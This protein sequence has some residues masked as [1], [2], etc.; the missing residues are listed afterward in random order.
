MAEQ[1]RPPAPIDLSVY[2][3]D[4]R[5]SISPPSVG[6][7]PVILVVTN[8][9]SQTESLSIT[10]AGSGSAL[11]L[12]G[13]VSPQATAQMQV[14]LDS[15]GEYTVASAATGNTDAGLATASGVVSA[16]LHV[17]VTRR[18]ASGALLQP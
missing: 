10:P 18:S 8:Q 4:A 16:A 13:P 12:I 14:D 1:P 5:L 6:A 15:P 11:A 9:A 3:A 2:I 7:G 17:G